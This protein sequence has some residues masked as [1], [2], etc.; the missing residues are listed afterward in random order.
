MV[1]VDPKLDIFGALLN[2]LRD[3]METMGLPFFVFDLSMFMASLEN[4]GDK[5]PLLIRQAHEKA[6]R[7]ILSAETTVDCIALLDKIS[8]RIQMFSE[9]AR[10]SESTEKFVRGITIQREFCI[11]C[12]ENDE[13]LRGRSR[14]HGSRQLPHQ[15]APIQPEDGGAHVH[16]RHPA[17][18]RHSPRGHFPERSSG[19]DEELY[20]RRS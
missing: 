9:K 7:L 19:D 12:R 16:Q 1:Q 20:S 3:K 18:G 15:G 10:D 6:R 4:A 5:G 2:T 17:C 8:T 14:M 13:R 11:Y